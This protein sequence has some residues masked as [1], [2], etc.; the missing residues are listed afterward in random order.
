MYS[1]GEFSG[2]YICV[3]LEGFA[4]KNLYRRVGY[5]HFKLHY[6]RIEVVKL[7]PGAIEPI[8][9]AQIVPKTEFLLNA[10]RA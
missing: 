8:F 7:P 2:Q 10:Q 3:P 1:S 6:H 4:H 5:K 9:F